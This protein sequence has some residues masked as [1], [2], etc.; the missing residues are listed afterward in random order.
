VSRPQ[1]DFHS[2]AASGILVLL[3]VLLTMNTVAI[4]LRNKYTRDDS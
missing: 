3:A 4:L 2:L 1:P